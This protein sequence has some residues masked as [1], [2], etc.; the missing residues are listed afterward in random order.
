[1]AAASILIASL[2]IKNDWADREVTRLS[3]ARSVLVGAAVARDF[4]PTLIS[5]LDSELRVAADEVTSTIPV[6]LVHSIASSYF[7]GG[8]EIRP[9]KRAAA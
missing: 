4:Q 7:I 1:M 5:A 2:P 8:I 9:S 6:A 3:S